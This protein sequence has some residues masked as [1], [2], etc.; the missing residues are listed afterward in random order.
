MDHPRSR[1]VYAPWLWPVKHT[2]GSSPLA[3]G[4]QSAISLLVLGHGIIPARAG[5]TPSPAE[6]P[7]RESGSSPLAWGL[8]RHRT[9]TIRACRIIPAR[10]G[11]TW[12][13]F[14]LGLGCWDHPRSRGVYADR[15]RIAALIGGSSPLARGLRPRHRPGDRGRR[16]IP[17]RAG[18]TRDWPRGRHRASDHPRS[19]GVYVF[20]VRTRSSDRG[21][22]PLARGLRV[23]D[24]QRPPRQGIIP[25]RAGFTTCLTAHKVPLRDHPRSRGVYG[26]DVRRLQCRVGSSPLARG[27]L[28]DW[29]CPDRILIGSSPLARGLPERLHHPRMVGGIIPARAGFTGHWSWGG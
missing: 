4:L 9:D 11:F 28:P 13:S 2:R 12:R 20:V 1:G 16:I 15:A 21:S 17:A 6:W 5:F 23:D 8:P 29:V 10:A 25:A 24:A 26:G 22:S 3:R 14:R 7:A 18:F 27:L 19:R